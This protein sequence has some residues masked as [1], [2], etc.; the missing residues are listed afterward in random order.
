MILPEARCRQALFA[1]PEGE[2]ARGFFALPDDRDA[3]ADAQADMTWSLACTGKFV[4]PI[5]DRGLK[6]RIHR[7]GAPTLILWGEEDRVIAPAYAQDFAAPI[8]G[9]RVEL[10][11][12]AGHLPH[13][14]QP[15]RVTALV[16]DVLRA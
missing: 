13:L 3:R 15:D 8:R 7:I 5:P 10:I 6:K 4:W 11:A 2:V 12:G 14:E 1:D 9:A 16:H